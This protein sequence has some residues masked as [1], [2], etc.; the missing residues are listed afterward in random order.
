MS[1]YCARTD[2]CKLPL[3]A[4]SSLMGC[5]LEVQKQGCS[6]YEGLLVLFL[7]MHIT[8]SYKDVESKC[9]RSGSG[10]GSFFFTLT[11]MNRRPLAVTLTSQHN[12]ISCVPAEITCCT[13]LNQVLHRTQRQNM[14][15]LWL[16]A[17]RQLFPLYML[18]HLRFL[19][20][21]SS[22]RS[23]FCRRITSRRTCQIHPIAQS[24][25]SSLRERHEYRLMP[26]LAGDLTHPI[27]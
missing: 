25:H 14:S 12:T 26:L 9:K 5:F 18:P 19:S 8:P 16:T 1:C 2:A 10:V 17:S 23:W 6:P 3:G 13:S 11:V 20:R 24:I 15:A 27:A 22:L 21:R 4:A 7:L